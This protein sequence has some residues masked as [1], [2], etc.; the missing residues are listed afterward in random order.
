MI[1]EK[2][3]ALHVRFQDVTPVL[4]LTV[5]V[6]LGSSVTLFVTFVYGFHTIVSRRP[7]WD[8]ISDLCPSIMGPWLVM[9]DFHNV[10]KPEEKLNG[11]PVTDY[12]VRD[13]TLCCSS[14]GLSYLNS[15][16]CFFTW[17]NNTVMS[18]LDRALVNDLWWMANFRAYA[19]F[20]PRVAYLITRRVLSLFFIL[21]TVLGGL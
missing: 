15:V 19:E 20:L 14:S 13:P 12:E 7:L 17:T 21:R 2:R 10:F 6:G 18:K 3:Y 9:G 16:G 5:M 11:L 4:L 1:C 8:T